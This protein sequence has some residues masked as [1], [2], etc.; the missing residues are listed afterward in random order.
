MQ[1]LENKTVVVPVDFSEQSI[2]AVDKALEIA[3][4]STSIHVVHVIDPTPIMIS[5]DPALPVPASYDHGRYE[6]ALQ[7][8]QKRFG[9]GP[10]AGLK[11]H[12][13]VGDPGSVITDYANS[14]RANMIIMPSHG[15][16]GIARLLMGSV[17]ERVL[18]LAHC[19]VL[20]LREPKSK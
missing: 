11:I 7:E 10:Y 18:R 19:P 8:L 6:Q 9:E 2:Q 1:Y 3:E 15:R 14:I 12:C 13:A 4:D 5:M 16:T 20:V 17:A